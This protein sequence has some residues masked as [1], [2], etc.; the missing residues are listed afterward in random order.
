MAAKENKTV[1]KQAEQLLDDLGFTELPIRPK[2]ICQA[3]SVPE[4]PVVYKEEPFQSDAILGMAM[5]GGILVNSNIQ[6]LGRRNFTGA[7]EIGHLVLHIQTNKKTEFQCNESNIFGSAKNHDK[8]EREADLFAASLL[9][10]QQL[11]HPLI[12]RVDLDWQSISNVASK[13]ETSLLATSKR[14]V[15]LAEEPIAL[16]IHQGNTFWQFETSSSFPY[17]IG[18]PVLPDTIERP[19]LNSDKIANDVGWH[20]ADAIDW[21]DDSSLIDNKEIQY[22]SIFVS[23]YKWTMTLLTAEENDDE[24]DDT[25]EDPHF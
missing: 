25:W 20:E 21:L 9:M 24:D 15:S 1:G 17:F 12:L 11:I 23:T 4:D 7:H 6:N 18:R 5:S 3:L 10:P 13:C 16:V 14:L 8:F 19:Q 2:R 22:S